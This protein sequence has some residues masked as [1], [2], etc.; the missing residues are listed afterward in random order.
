M[1]ATAS[2]GDVNHRPYLLVARPFPVR[3]PAPSVYAAPSTEKTID[4]P[5]VTVPSVPFED[6]DAP[7]VP[8]PLVPLVPIDAP[9]VPVAEEPECPVCL[10][11]HGDDPFVTSCQ[12][13]FCRPCIQKIS[14]LHCPRYGDKTIACPLCRERVTLT[15]VTNRPL[16]ATKC[17]PTM[18]PAEATFDFIADPHEREMIWNAYRTIHTL[19]KWAYLHAVDVDP[20]R[21]FMFSDDVVFCGIMN[22]VATDYD[23]HSGYTMGY[24]MRKMQFIAKYGYNAFSQ[25]SQLH[26]YG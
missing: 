2:V 4:E 9:Q 18:Y 21:G 23:N 5:Q 6:I 15:I 24:T 16:P 17:C 8:V 13:S 11:P 19:D 7:Q 20:E 26:V 3:R 25:L 14:E 22:Q 10:L 12:H 1:G